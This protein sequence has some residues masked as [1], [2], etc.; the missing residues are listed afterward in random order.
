VQDR[1][2]TA[3]LINDRWIDAN[4]Q[5]FLELKNNPL[6]EIESHGMQHKPLSATGRSVYNIQGTRIVEKASDEVTL[7]ADGIYE[8]SGK[9]PRFF[10]AGTAYCDK[11]AIKAVSELGYDDVGFSILGDAG[12][13]YNKD[14]IVRMPWRFVHDRRDVIIAKFCRIRTVISLRNN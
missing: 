7:S 14:Q 4:M 9:R 10:R 12:A 13:Y 11:V 6:L 3:W 8:F 2:N 1:I 5:T